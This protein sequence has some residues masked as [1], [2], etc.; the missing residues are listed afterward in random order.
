VFEGNPGEM[1]AVI[2]ECARDED[3]PPGFLQAVR[4]LCDKHGVVLIF[5]EVSAAWR[6]VPSARHM[7]YVVVALC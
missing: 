1:A 3:P 7:K 4:D 2:M 6:D 5:D